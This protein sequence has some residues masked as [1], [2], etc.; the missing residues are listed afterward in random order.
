MHT[1]VYRCAYAHTVSL[2]TSPA[3]SPPPAL[4]F[5]IPVSPFVI[6][7]SAAK[8]KA[9]RE[10]RS[11]L[12]LPFFFL[13]FFIFVLALHQK[14]GGFFCHG[15]P[16]SGKCARCGS[17]SARQRHPRRRRRRRPETSLLRPITRDGRLPHCAFTRGSGAVWGLRG[18]SYCRRPCC[19]TAPSWAHAPSSSSTTPL[20]G[21]AAAA[22]AAQKYESVLS[23]LSWEHGAV[24][25]PLQVDYAATTRGVI[26]HNC[27]QVCAVLDVLDVRWTHFLTHSYGCLVAAYMAASEAFPHRIGTFISL[28]TPLMTRALL[29]N[30]QQREEIAKAE[31]DVNVPA[32]DLSF[33]KESLMS[34]L[35]EPLPCPAEADAGLYHDYLFNP[36]AV[37]RHGGLVRCEERY[38]PVKHLADVRHPMQLVVPA[39]NAVA[40]AAVHKEFFGLRRPVV[41]K[42]C[43]RHEELFQEEGAKELAKVLEAWL[44]RFEPDAYLAKRYEQ[45]AKEMSQLMMSSTPATAKPEAAEGGEQRKKKKEKKKKA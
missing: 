33:A 4:Q 34:S 17:R 16:W 19:T 22:A 32:A 39:A 6:P 37:F 13:F 1:C 21:G 10:R 8:K 43:Q 2:S 23:Q 5:S 29:Q 15:L 7:V 41:L 26:E 44:Q 45:A 40:D 9:Q 3:S 42:G 38:V 18:S 36:A 24:Y 11:Y 28:D 30:T 25:V 14:G 12:F 27:Q 35:E 20:R 31:R